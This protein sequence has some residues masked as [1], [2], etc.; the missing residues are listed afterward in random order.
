MVMYKT[1]YIYCYTE[2]VNCIV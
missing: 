2:C 1:I